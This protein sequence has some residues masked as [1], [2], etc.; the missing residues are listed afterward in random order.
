MW[1]DNETNDDL[2]GFRVHAD[3][4]REL[5]MDPTVL[6]ATIGVYG[7]WGGGKSSIMQMLKDDFEQLAAGDGADADS[8]KGVAILYFNGWLFEGYDDAKAALLS[9]I[10]TSL[11]DHKKFGPK[12]RDKAAQLLKSVDYMRALRLLFTGA[13]TGGIAAATGGIGAAA[14]LPLLATGALAGAKDAAPEAAKGALEKAS[15]APVE[16]SLNDIRKF[17][18][19]FA[20]MLAKSDIKTLVI[21]IDD[22]DRCSPERIIENLEAIKLFLN[23]PNTAFVIG[24]DRRV[25]RQAVAWRYREAI[26]AVAN[27]NGQADPADRLVD[28]YLEKLIQIPYRLPRLSPSEIET[29]LTLLFCKRHLSPEL[30]KTVCAAAHHQRAE[31]RYRAFGLG[32]VLDVLKTGVCPPALNESLRIGANIASQIT[33]VLQGNPRQV[34][35]F[36]NAFFL[37][38]RLAQVA[39]LDEVKDEVLVKLMLLEYAAPKLFDRLFAGMDGNTGLVAIMADLEPKID[40]KK[41][42]PKELPPEWAPMNRWLAMSPPLSQLDL[43]DYMWVTRDRLGT[44]LSGTTMIS[45][46]VR[47]LLK[48]LM[49]DLSQ[50]A[51]LAAIKNINQQERSVLAHQLVFLAQRTPGDLKPFRAL[52]EIA[53]LDDSVAVEFIKLIERTP[54]NDLPPAL[55]LLIQGY[56]GKQSAF[57]QAC[58]K[59]ADDL[60]EDTSRF[61]KSLR[62]KQR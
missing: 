19:E 56:I 62:Q 46:M 14:I 27:G 43:R 52:E 22:L 32:C 8:Y 50:K 57:G 1:P 38:R 4:I 7:D 3:L 23:V 40:G 34:K 6:P 39:K 13:V 53:Q 41:E 11:R 26:Q 51:G 59:L 55:G 12:L 9:S 58:R 5:I 2:F 15:E 25:I 49:G 60:K 20:D 18:D 48:Q 42:P 16:E 35:R 28:D 31:D 37:R 54:K 44:T 10:L 61:A 30:F 36:L 24:A 45:P 29:Y 33:D 17:R 21:L 47:A